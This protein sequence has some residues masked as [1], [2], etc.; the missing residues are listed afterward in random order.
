MSASQLNSNDLKERRTGLADSLDI[1]P[2]HQADPGLGRFLP[3]R[4]SIIEVAEGGRA[5]Y[6]QKLD[7]EELGLASLRKNVTT[8]QQL[9]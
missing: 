8:P 2:A 9:H 4:I 6:R 1:L 5:F 3:E 7:A